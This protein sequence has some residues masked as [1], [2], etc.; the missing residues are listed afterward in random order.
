MHIILVGSN[1]SEWLKL[2]AIIKCVNYLSTQKSK[3]Y[4]F[5]IIEHRIQLV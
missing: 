3:I 5:L 2:R 1:S 4:M